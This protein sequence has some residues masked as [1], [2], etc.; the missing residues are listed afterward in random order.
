MEFYNIDNEDYRKI[1]KHEVINPMIKI[2]LL[3][4]YEN[5]YSE[6]IEDI[7]AEQIGTISESY[8]QGVRKTISFSIFD[9]QGEFIPDPNNKNFWIN[10]KFKIYIGLA[11]TR[12]FSK[13]NPLIYSYNEEDLVAYL[14]YNNPNNWDDI[15]ASIENSPND[16]IISIGQVDG[17]IESEE[18]IYWF[19]KGVYVI[20]D[21][22]AS[23]SSAEKTVTINGVDKFGMFGSETGYNEMIGTFSIPQG[24]TIYE[25]IFTILNQDMGNGKVLDPIEP[26]ID[27]YYRNVT[28]PFDIDKGPGSY[29]SES[30]TDLATTFRADI[31]YDDD[32]RLNFQR[33]MLGEENINLPNIWDFYDTDSEYINSSLTYNL[34]K[35]ANRVCV[36]GDNPN[37]SVAPIGISENRNA[38]SPISIQKIGVKNKY[39]ESSTIQTMTE[40]KDY[41][42]Y[43]LESLSI[44][45][46]TISFECTLIPSLTVNKLFTLT[47]TFYKII[48]ESF[49]IE[50]LTCPMG[51]GTMTLSGS[52]IKELP[53]Y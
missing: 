21:I 42:D 18:D 31:F 20:T 3:D 10:R 14:K 45:Q 15:E 35:T 5:T 30:L 1:A 7:S 29:L 39:L 32:G 11:K 9:P 34:V 50:S 27:P 16:G 17:E 48:K 6:L 4:D 33:S 26:I 19:S 12:F 52:N 2:E 44:T 53:T 8:Q 24:F 47:D 22:N 46:N 41:A 49:L 40:A 37:G 13:D 36:V 28:I 51:I 38:S 25:A 43:I 23:H